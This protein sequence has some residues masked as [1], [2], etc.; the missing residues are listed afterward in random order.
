VSQVAEI[1][2][3]DKSALNLRRG[4]LI[5]VP[6]L[7]LLIVFFVLVRGRWR[8]DDRARGR[9]RQQHEADVNVAFT[10]VRSSGSVS[11]RW[12]L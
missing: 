2:K 9:G 10:P 4:V 3:I 11:C 6:S 5:M 7:L 1:F 8:P 12:A